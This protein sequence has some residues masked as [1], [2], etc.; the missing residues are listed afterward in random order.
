MSLLDYDQI[1]GFKEAVN[2][3]QVNRELAFLPAP[4]P[5]LGVPIRHFNARHHMLLAGCG[6]RFIC[7][8]IP[9]PE[10]V[11]MFLWFLSPDYR[12]EPGYRE[13]FVEKKIKDLDYREAVLA[14][15]K[16][17]DA[18]FQDWGSGGGGNEK[19]FTAPIAAFIDVLAFEYGWTDEAILEMPL[20]RV[21]QFLRRIQMRKNPRAL[22][23][24]RSER[25]VGE[26]L[27]NRM[28]QPT[29][30]GVN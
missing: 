5:I 19:Q 6:N 29:V 26:Y 13:P 30:E 11:A 3:E 2:R 27:R 18:V 4:M 17:L 8:G 7:G 25:L 10:D 28:A 16:Y 12:T 23:F 15:L 9:R 21:F 1:P 20:A 24:N 14:I 22:L